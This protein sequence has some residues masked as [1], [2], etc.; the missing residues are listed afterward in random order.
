MRLLRAILLNERQSFPRVVRI[1]DAVFTTPPPRA[2]YP[3]PTLNTL[4][5]RP[6]DHALAHLMTSQWA[7]FI[8]DYTPNHNGVANAP[9]WP[10]Y[11]DTKENYVFERQEWHLEVDDWREEAIAYVNELGTQLS[12]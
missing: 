12:V 5:T 10:N 2:Q 7:S 6:G 3:F 8:A 9:S 1:T 4:G 11:V